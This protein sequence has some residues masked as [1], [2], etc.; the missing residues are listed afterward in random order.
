[1]NNIV[2]IELIPEELSNEDNTSYVKMSKAD[3]W[4]L[5]HLLKKYNPKKNC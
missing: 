2:E 4:F 5:K 1:M 3:I